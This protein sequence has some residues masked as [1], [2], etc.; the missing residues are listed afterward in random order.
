MDLIT[1]RTIAL[2]G[3]IQACQQVQKLA[4]T[5]FYEDD[6]ALASL[7]SILILDALNTPAVYGGVIGVRS[8]LIALQ[9]GVLNSASADGIE[10]LRYVMSVLQLPVSYTHLTLPTKRIV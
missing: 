9:G 1:E 3:V 4:R 6:D 7:N 5:G 8:G 2:A 10:V